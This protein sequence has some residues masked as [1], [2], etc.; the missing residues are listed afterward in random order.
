M[1][2]KKK[3]KPLK[4]LKK[5]AWKEFS[6]YVRQSNADWRGYVPCFTC[7]VQL[8][9]NSEEAHA[10]HFI[11]DKLDF[12]PININPQCQQWNY[13]KKGNIRFSNQLS[14]GERESINPTKTSFDVLLRDEI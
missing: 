8:V 11:H 4:S 10:G 14:F 9:W 2:P 3:L 13:W 5:L 12:D 7:G 1:K 6:I